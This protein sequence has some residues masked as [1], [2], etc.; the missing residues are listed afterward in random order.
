MP[1]L[2][3]C[4]E[5]TTFGSAQSCNKFETDV[6]VAKRRVV[7][8]RRGFQ[9]SENADRGQKDSFCYRKLEGI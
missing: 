7:S 5:M 8:L 1:P 4:P 9:M 3:I 2:G 6:V